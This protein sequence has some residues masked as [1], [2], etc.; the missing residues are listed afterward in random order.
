[1]AKLHL[2]QS[3][4]LLYWKQKANVKWMSEGDANTHFFNNTVK[5][6]RR[7]QTIKHIIQEGAMECDIPQDIEQAAVHYYQTSFE[8]SQTAQYEEIL[9]YIPNLLSEEDNDFLLAIPTIQEVKQAVLDLSPT[10]AVGPD[11]FPGSFYRRFWQVIS[12]NVLKTAQE[13]FLGIIP[14][15]R[16]VAAL[17]T[18]IPKV[19]SPSRFAKFRPI[20]LTNFLAKIITRL[21]AT[22]LQTIL[23]RLISHEQA[24]FMKGRDITEQILLAQE[25][26]HLLDNHMRGGHVIIKLD[27]GKAFDR[28]CWAYLE[29]LLRKMGFLSRL[30]RILLN[31]LSATRFSVLINGKPARYFSVSRGVKQGDPLS[32]LL[33]I[34]AAEGFSHGLNT[35]MQDGVIRG[36]NAER[37]PLVSH[38]AFLNDLVIFLS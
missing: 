16:M 13:F 14:P 28:V 31:N 24:G 17:I 2:A 35:L 18:L 38:L 19:S 37:V 3:R 1:M 5:E 29:Q 32:P 11:G 10:S 6:R 30:V 15:T 7:R 20:Y 12:L 4:T 21:F 34:L 22:R 26:V 27:M 33:F 9:Q 23:P 25:M 8:R 36:F